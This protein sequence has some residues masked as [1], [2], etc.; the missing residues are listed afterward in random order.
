MLVNHRPVDPMG[1]AGLAEAAT[2]TGIK[3]PRT[4]KSEVSFTLAG[5]P[6]GDIDEMSVLTGQTLGKYSPRRPLL[7]TIAD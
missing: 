3:A 6:A 7:R 5:R 1:S 4:P 2:C